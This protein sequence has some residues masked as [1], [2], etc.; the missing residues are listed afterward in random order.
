M[1]FAKK[2]MEEQ[3]ID[4]TYAMNTVLDEIRSWARG[5]ADLLKMNK[6]YMHNHKTVW[7]GGG[8]FL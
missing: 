8:Y 3:G 6:K 1:R 7:R 4:P 5:L 2:E